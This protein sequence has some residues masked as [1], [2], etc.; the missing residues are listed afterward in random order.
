[1]FLYAMI[2]QKS[3]L[4]QFQ[5]ILTI[6]SQILKGLQIGKYYGRSYLKEIDRKSSQSRDSM[7]FME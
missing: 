6:E 5:S 1:M 4:S 7:F 3:V 2:E